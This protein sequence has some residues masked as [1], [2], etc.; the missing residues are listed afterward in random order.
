MLFYYSK[1]NICIYFAQYLFLVDI[2]EFLNKYI[3]LAF[4]CWGYFLKNIV[5]LFFLDSNRFFLKLRNSTSILVPLFIQK[6]VA[7]VSSFYRFLKVWQSQTGWKIKPV[8][9]ESHLAMTGSE[10]WDYF[11]SYMLLSSVNFHLLYLNCLA[12]SF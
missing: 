4:I 11:L 12:K 9:P 10:S 7:E 3:N 2:N 8:S 5:C 1:V 6:T